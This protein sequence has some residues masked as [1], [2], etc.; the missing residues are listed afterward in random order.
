MH[1]SK[2]KTVAAALFA[3]GILIG[4]GT[5]QDNSSS[6]QVDA[7]P[8]A[9]T[10]ALASKQA[11]DT[12]LTRAK[13]QGGADLKVS[14]HKATDMARFLRV[15]ASSSA[16]L[17]KGAAKTAAA[18]ASESATFFRD[19]GPA[20]GVSDPASMRLESTQ[21][22][23]LGHTHLTYRQYHAGIPVFGAMLKTHFDK[24][25]R[26]HEVAGTAIP[27]IS[28][29]TT[30][31]LSRDQAGA[32]ARAAVVADRGDSDVIQ[33]RGGTLYVFREGLA[34]GV[35]GEN[36]LAWEV[37]VSDGGYVRELVY[38]DAHRG[39]VIDRINMVQDAMFRRAYDGHNLPFVPNNYPNG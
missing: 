27:D 37:E 15:R 2:S 29:N 17:G 13:Q 24:N 7:V 32:V 18:Q 26:L 3:M 28:V 36:H 23:E 20:M 12:A 1:L 16:S 33:P 31:T 21:T 19:F 14:M 10:N 30:P 5:A 35:P 38:V 11:R 39:K 6:P 8:I 34:R 25:G 4:C 9:Q 22:D